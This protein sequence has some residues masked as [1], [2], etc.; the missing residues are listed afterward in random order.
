M[1][2]ALIASIASYGN[3]YREEYLINKYNP[4]TLLTNWWKALDYFFSRA[5]F[6]GRRDNISN[7]VYEAVKNVLG[8]QFSGPSRST[9]YKNLR[10]Q[11]WKPVKR[12]LRQRIGK[13]KV[14]KARDVNMV[15][16]AL[17][18]IGHLPG[19][20]I[21]RHSTDEIR[22]GRINTHYEELQPRRS[23]KGITQ[24][25]P[26]IAAFYLRDL[27][28]LYGLEDKVP[29]EYAFCLQPVDVWV[30]KVARQLGIVDQGANPDKIQS[31]IIA[32]CQAEG[33]SP[34]LFNQGAWYVGSNAFDLVLEILAAQEQR[35]KIKRLT[36]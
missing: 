16:S 1:N 31:A 13:G 29:A 22:G 12:A 18:Y 17:E 3:R 32:H 36:T 33:I 24:V 27:V 34:L 6:Q 20:N 26:K 11:N 21:V 35:A 14:G 2:S 23:R 5:C 8:P 7:K 10:R 28:S 25:G 30:E 15:L 4:Q 19:L 9:N